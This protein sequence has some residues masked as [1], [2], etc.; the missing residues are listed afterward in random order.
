MVQRAARLGFVWAL[1]VVACHDQGAQSVPR[2][3]FIVQPS[4]TPEGAVLS[5]PIQVAAQDASGNTVTTFAGNVTLAIGT[6]PVGGTLSGTTTVAA[7]SGIATFPDLSIS[8]AGDG[9]TLLASAAGFG[10]ATSPAFDAVCISNY[11]TVKAPMPTVRTG[12]GVGTVNGMLYTVGGE[13]IKPAVATVEAYDPKTEFWTTQAPMPT[14]RSSPGVGVVNG[15]LYAVG[16]IPAGLVD[17]LPTGTIEAYD[18]VS[19]TWTTKQP[20]PTPR[21]GLGVGV[22]NGI[23]YAVGGVGPGG[24]GTVV[25]GAV[26][27]YDPVSNTWTAKAPMPTPRGGVALGVVNGLLYAVGGEGSGGP[28]TVVEVYDPISSTWASKASVPTARS[29][30]GLGVVNGILYAIGGATGTGAS[31]SIVNTV[32]AY[33]PATNTWTTKEPMCTGRR[34][35]A[36]GV[37]N[38]VLYAIGGQAT[39]PGDYTGANEAYR[40]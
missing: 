33:D 21:F 20:M 16:G 8:V 30:F 7:S 27:A 31:A 5:P 18:P 36:I 24:S 40:P 1:L 11:W 37:L 13:I 38:G 29:G 15:L 22:V 25:T 34:S 3:G 12:F 17:P 19:N 23:I 4:S 2:L 14:A 26:E 32:E 39:Y 35:L 9:Y 10:A 28:L 6:N